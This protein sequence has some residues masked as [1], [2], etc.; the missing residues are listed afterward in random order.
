MPTLAYVTLHRHAEQFL[1]AWVKKALK[2]RSDNARKQALLIGAEL[3]R[4]ANLL[5]AKG[6]EFIPL[7]G[8][9]LSLR[10][11]GDPG[12]RHMKDL[13]IL[14]KPEDV[15]SAD[16]LLT[17]EG[18]ICTI[19]GYDLTEKQRK[20]F[21]A[22]GYHYNYYHPGRGI[23]IE[24]HWGSNLWTSEQVSELWAGVGSLEWM[25]INF[26]CL[27]EDH[28]LLFLCG[29]GAGH[30]WFR[31][32]WLSDIAP[33]ISR[34]R[35]E[36]WERLIAISERLDLSR[37]LAQASL[38][39]HWMYD[40]PLPEPI[41]LLLEKEKVSFSLTIKAVEAMNDTDDMEVMGK[42]LDSL[43]SAWYFLRLRKYAVS[44][45]SLKRL[46]VCPRDFNDFPLPDSLFW[47]YGPLRPFFWFFRHF[48]R[49]NRK[50]VDI[51]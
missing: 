15:E 11:Y 6:I 21:L 3:V 24:L 23:E 39:S 17:S 1:P 36:G 19:P 2:E 12:I 13:D 27:D 22:E 51:H 45:N 25:G 9:L 44:F 42:R 40:I 26:N 46:F 48:V 38:L 18:Y 32:K 34:Q 4:L 41:L 50:A 30:K 8:A 43:R 28:L 49:H 5:T 37:S 14:V 35:P 33:L 31:L 10:L 7:R 16:R 47:L 29:H 20:Y